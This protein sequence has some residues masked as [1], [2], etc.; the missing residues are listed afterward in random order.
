M[1]MQDI[2]ENMYTCRVPGLSIG[3]SDGQSGGLYRRHN[4][5]GRRLES[6]RSQVLRHVLLQGLAVL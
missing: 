2:I 1:S 6:L 4:D 3:E 5:H